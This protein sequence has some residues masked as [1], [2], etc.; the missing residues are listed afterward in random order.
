MNSPDPEEY[1]SPAYRRLISIITDTDNGREYPIEPSAVNID[2]ETFRLPGRLTPFFHEI[3]SEPLVTKRVNIRFAPRFTPPDEFAGNSEKE[4][5]ILLENRFLVIGTE[6]TDVPFYLTVDVADDRLPVQT[7][8]F[9]IDPYGDL[10]EQDTLPPVTVLEHVADSFPA[11][12]KCMTEIEK[13]TSAPLYTTPVRSEYE[14]QLRTGLEHHFGE[15]IVQTWWVGRLSQGRQDFYWNQFHQKERE[16]EYKESVT[17]SVEYNEAVFGLFSFLVQKK[18]TCIRYFGI[19]EDCSA[20]PLLLDLLACEENGEVRDEII[21]AAANMRKTGL[22]LLKQAAETYPVLRGRLGALECLA[23]L[24]YPPAA[25]MLLSIYSSPDT[26]PYERSCAAS[27]LAK[28]ETWLP[29]T[30]PSAD[31]IL[32]RV[33]NQREDIETCAE[34]GNE[35][36]EPE[37]PVL[38]RI[39]LPPFDIRDLSR[40]RYMSFLVILFAA[41][42]CGGGFYLVTGNIL[43]M[44]FGSTAV[45]AASIFLPDLSSFLLTRKLSSAGYSDR[46]IDIPRIQEELQNG[47]IARC[48]EYAKEDQALSIGY[49]FYL[50]SDLEQGELRP[51][52]YFCNTEEHEET[53]AAWYEE[54]LI[55]NDGLRSDKIRKYWEGNVKISEQR[56]AYR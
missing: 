28:A 45:V 30:D 49:L 24:N 52:I 4:W 54:G 56:T 12:L 9:D 1:T 22:D 35:P 8:D 20:I 15:P 3:L 46:R 19:L 48:I 2:D 27:L 26:P 21:A 13:H 39:K 42:L 38:Y 17:G 43:S 29:E 11:F 36:S 55:P 6:L 41:L 14:A 51:W 50:F 31:D 16:I 40:I 5:G 32:N 18:V 47:N 37:I 44:I 33:R 25:E 23:E 7:I 53:A 34:S 10:P